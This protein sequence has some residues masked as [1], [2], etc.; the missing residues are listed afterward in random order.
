MIAEYKYPFG[1]IFTRD[2]ELE[3]CEL[4]KILEKGKWKEIDK[5]E[6][7]ESLFYET[8]GNYRHKNTSINKK[9]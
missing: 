9:I 6:L 7:D 4:Y 2:S 8:S 3:D 5:I 1:T